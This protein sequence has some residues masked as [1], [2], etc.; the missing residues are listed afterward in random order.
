MAA[1]LCFTIRASG[2]AEFVVDEDFVIATI[3]NPSQ[4]TDCDGARV[5][6]FGGYYKVVGASDGDFL[7]EIGLRSNDVIQSINT[8]PL[9]GSFAVITAF[10]DLWPGT[11]SFTLSVNRPGVGTFS[12]DID[13]I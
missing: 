5:E 3:S 12:I 4:L 6:P 7:Y 13:L 11:T 9:T 8:Y 1:G 10:Y 2:T